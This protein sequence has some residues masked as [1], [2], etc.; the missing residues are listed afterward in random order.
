M[1]SP[2]PTSGYSNEPT[3]V[4]HSHD[5]KDLTFVTEMIDAGSDSDINPGE[6]TFEE[7]LS[8]VQLCSQEI[9]LTCDARHCRRDGSPFGCLQLHDA[10][11]TT[12]PHLIYQIYLRCGCD[13]RRRH[14]RHWY[15]LHSIIHPRVRRICGRI[16]DALG[17]WIRPLVLRALRLAR[18]WHHV[19]TV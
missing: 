17:P 1:S 10:Q 8:L 15:I 18:I 2:L 19:S 16:S 3:A 6:L 4:E 11:V 14:H 13:Q 9:S 12:P 7:G 5:E